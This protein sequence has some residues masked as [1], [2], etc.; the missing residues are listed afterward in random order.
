MSNLLGVLYDS[1]TYIGFNFFRLGKFF[2]YYFVENIFCTFEMGF[3]SFLYTYC[4][5][6]SFY[7]SPYFLNVLCQKIFRVNILFDQYIFLLLYL[8]VCIFFSW[9][10][11]HFLI[12]DIFT[13]FLQL[14]VLVSLFF[15]FFLDFL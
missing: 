8:S 4:T 7:T 9:F 2:F 5:D 15:C 10:Y 3:F 6:W 14:F 1:S 12:L 13:H 11:F